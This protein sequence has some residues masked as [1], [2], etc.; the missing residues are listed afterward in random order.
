MIIEKPIPSKSQRISN[1]LGLEVILMFFGLVLMPFLFFEKV[2]F[3][4]SIGMV[5]FSIVIITFKLKTKGTFY[6]YKLELMDNLINIHFVTLKEA[7]MIES[8]LFDC[9]VSLNAVANMSTNIEDVYLKIKVQNK[10]FEFKRLAG[11]KH[12]EQ[13]MIFEI[14]CKKQFHEYTEDDL[15]WLMWIDKMIEI[16][17]S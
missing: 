8:S 16:F 11:W 17:E 10:S 7:K 14:I 6:P 12:S 13:K 15:H 3:M 9:D 5:L 2:L 4:I 1:A